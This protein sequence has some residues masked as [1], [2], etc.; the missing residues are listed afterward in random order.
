MHEHKMGCLFSNLLHVS[1]INCNTRKLF[2]IDFRC[3]RP[4]M[5]PQKTFK[6][7]VY[8]LQMSVEIILVTPT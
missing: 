2:P 4:N 5:A 8:I 3:I 1:K 7:C 6:T